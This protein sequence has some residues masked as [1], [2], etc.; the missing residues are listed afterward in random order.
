MATIPT[1]NAVPSEAPRD[2]KFNSGKIDELVTSLEHEYKDRFGRSH[3][4]VEGMRW[5]FEQLMERFKV[6]INQAIIAAGYITMDSFQLGAEITKRNEILR[7]ETTGE[8]YRWDGDL[9][10]TVPAGSTPD[11]TGG[12]GKLAWVGVGANAVAD[13]AKRS[14]AIS[15]SIQDAINASQPGQTVLTLNEDE[16]VESL[17][18]D[19]GV[20]IDAR[21]GRVFNSDGVQLT[22]YAEPKSRFVIGR[23]YLWAIHKRMINSS[24]NPGGTAKIVWSG[25]S[26]TFGVNAGAWDPVSIANELRFTYGIPSVKNF[27]E[28]HNAKTMVDWGGWYVNKDI[29]K[30]PDMDCYVLRWGINDGGVTPYTEF[31]NALRGGLTALREWKSVEKLSV[32]LMM[33][34]STSDT[35]TGKDE[36]WYEQIS[37]AYRQA[38]RDFKCMFFDTYATWRDARGKAAGAWLDDPYGDGRGIHP[39]SILNAQIIG[40]ICHY[41]YKPCE[42]V[43][44]K[45]NKFINSPSS[46]QQITSAYP[47]SSFPYGIGFYRTDDASKTWPV[48]GVVKVESFIDGVSVQNLY[49]YTNEHQSICYTRIG[50]RTGSWSEWR[51]LQNDM[52]PILKSGWVIGASR[53]AT[54]QKSLDGIITISAILTGGTTT[55]GG[56]IATLPVGF[57]PKYDISYIPCASNNAMVLINVLANGDMVIE[58]FPS[59]SVLSVN[60][61]FPSYIA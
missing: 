19:Y 49:G 59:G 20:E 2:L 60:I 58:Q 57:R 41:L 51:G 17:S 1:Q 13:M 55:K 22:T 11:S 25:D 48:N 21:R 10:K 28:G 40:D 43:N 37:G 8:Y 44:G 24:I 29:E 42:S 38:A 39:D 50:R 36:K 45:T 34:S 54:Y 3:L 5:I 14:G 26:T 35:R 23:E 16:I 31:V 30:H 32:I 52:T 18:N 27:N 33:P 61:N 9:P 15:E 7:D 47:P 53:S 6:D 4:T 56:I 12:I 46:I